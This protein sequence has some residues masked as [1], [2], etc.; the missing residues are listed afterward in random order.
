MYYGNI[1]RKDFKG[2]K[3]KEEN[4]DFESALKEAD[5]INLANRR[6]SMMMKKMLVMEKIER[7]IENSTKSKRMKLIPKLL[8][9]KR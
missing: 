8:V 5:K 9:V 1:Q 4:Q 3:I 7:F 6:K 2:P